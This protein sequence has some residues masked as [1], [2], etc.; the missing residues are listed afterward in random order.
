MPLVHIFQE[1]GTDQ[2]IRVQASLL[3]RNGSHPSLV[4]LSGTHN[5]RL[6]STRVG[7]VCLHNSFVEPVLLSGYV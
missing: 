2:C 7:G 5:L 1:W 6:E 4:I 3:H